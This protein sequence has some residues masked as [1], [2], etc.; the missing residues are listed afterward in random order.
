MR[1]A[2]SIYPIVQPLLKRLRRSRWVIR[3][4]FQVEIPSGTVVQFDP[5]TVL[6]AAMLPVCIEKQID[7]SIEQ[8]NQ[9][10]DSPGCLKVFE[11][12]IGEG[13]LV[14]IAIDRWNRSREGGPFDLQFSGV[15]CSTSR[16]DSSK[17]VA[18][19]N[20][21]RANFWVSD[22][23]ANVPADSA[24]DLVIFNPPYVPTHTGKSLRL[25][26]RLGID[27][28]QMWDGGEDGTEVLL[29]FLQSIPII[30][31]PNAKIVFGVQPIFVDE[32]KVLRTINAAGLTLSSIVKRSAIPAVVYVVSQH[33][34]QS[35]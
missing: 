29:R 13:A 15:D 7:S 19:F 35:T 17:R 18:E 9:P 28:D 10:N 12:G 21:T 33:P 25:T 24:Y 26:E 34:P 8:D 23:F 4:L 5:V 16:V 11:T 30:L 3:R 6:L 20:S 1:F 22:L 27:G 31:R 14:T 2:D 32:P